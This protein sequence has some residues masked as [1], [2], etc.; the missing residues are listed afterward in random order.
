M[1]VKQFE[2]F[3]L[4]KE[5]RSIR[6]AANILKISPAALSRRM[7]G[8][9]RAVGVTLF[10]RSKKRITLTEAGQ[11]FANDVESF[12]TQY[13]RSIARITTND[14][15]LYASLK[16]AITA[17]LIPFPLASVL[18]SLN[19]R[20]PN[21]HLELVDDREY[22]I[23]ESLASGEVD[24]YFTF[25]FGENYPDNVAIEPVLS[26]CMYALFRSDHRLAKNS[27]VS[28][29]D[30]DGEQFI[31]YPKTKATHIRQ[32]QQELLDNSG[33]RYSIY[34]TKTPHDLFTYFLPI[35]KGVILS[36]WPMNIKLTP[37]SVSIPIDNPDSGTTYYMLY[38]KDSKNPILQ[39]IVS[40]IC[41]LAK[42]EASR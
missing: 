28:L 8:F 34:E 18:D 4:V 7:A 41:A 2:E 23:R 19:F 6:T 16:I 25:C 15:H 29:Q 12:L 40:E 5:Q 36:P 20:Y 31:L 37:N 30:L 24:M 1:E 22:D 13:H 39:S 3:M 17:E 10:D 11:R 26:M 9:E 38:R 35:G 14:D 21:L 32:F 42:E 27:S 33:I